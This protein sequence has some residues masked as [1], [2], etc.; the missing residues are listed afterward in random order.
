VSEISRIGI[1]TGGGDAPGLNAVIRAVVK[2]GANAG[3]ECV[4]ISSLVTFLALA[5][6]MTSYSAINADSADTEE[7]TIVAGSQ[8]ESDLLNSAIVTSRDFNEKP[9]LVDGKVDHCGT[10]L[11]NL[12][13]ADG[14]W[15]IASV[16][17]TGRKDCSLK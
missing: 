7:V 11:F 10:D 3:I 14:K 6:Y 16:A 2:A 5:A 9:V 13:R 17:D 4:G 15:L 8:Q 12:V 1:L